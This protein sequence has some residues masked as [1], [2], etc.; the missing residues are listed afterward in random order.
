MHPV[1]MFTDDWLSH[2]TVAQL[3]AIKRQEGPLRQ[4]LLS[5]SLVKQHLQRQTRPGVMRMRAH[6]QQ[7]CNLGITICK[8]KAN[9]D[10]EQFTSVKLTK[11]LRIIVTQ[12]GFTYIAY[13]F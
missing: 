11:M 3:V 7:H 8:V 12:S 2:L 6:V 1:W 9:P 5:V 10:Y 4:E 13:I